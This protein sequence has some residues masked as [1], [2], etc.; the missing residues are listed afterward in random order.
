MCKK[1][2]P[3]E[4][5]VTSVFYCYFQAVGGAHF[6]NTESQRHKRYTYSHTKASASK[7]YLFCHGNPSHFQLESEWWCHSQERLGWEPSLSC[8]AA[9]NYISESNGHDTKTSLLYEALRFYINIDILSLAR[10]ILGWKMWLDEQ[11]LHM[12][13]RGCMKFWRIYPGVWWNCKWLPWSSGPLKPW[14]QSATWSGQR[15]AG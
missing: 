9:E 15:S 12:I 13:L 8:K 2:L 7:T 1:Y 4:L 14:G 11:Y 3:L 5:P 6:I 10:K